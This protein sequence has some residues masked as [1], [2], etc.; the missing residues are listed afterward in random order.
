[1]Y[2]YISLEAAWCIFIFEASFRI[3]AEREKYTVRRAEE[4]WP[5][6]TALWVSAVGQVLA[7]LA[8]REPFL[9]LFVPDSSITAEN[10]EMFLFLPARQNWEKGQEFRSHLQNAFSGGRFAE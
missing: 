1:M 4:R 3:I 7:A 9:I 6:S 2:F 5:S 10:P 8:L